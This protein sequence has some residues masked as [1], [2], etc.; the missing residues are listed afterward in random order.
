MAKLGA[1]S[2]DHTRPQTADF[3]PISM[4]SPR[5]RWRRWSRHLRTRVHLRRRRRSS[6]NQNNLT[7]LNFCLFVPIRHTWIF[8]LD[9]WV[10]FCPFR[11]MLLYDT[12]FVQYSIDNITVRIVS[13]IDKELLKVS[14][15]G[16]H[17]TSEK[18]PSSD[19]ERHLK[20]VWLPVT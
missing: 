20:Y 15:W 13:E 18:F 17:L 5:R 10:F 9:I 16:L 12:L 3:H 11:R 1:K 19:L 6:T 14:R 7:L 2:M 4:S 8:E